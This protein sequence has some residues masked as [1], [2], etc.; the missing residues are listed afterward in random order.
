M[1]QQKNQEAVIAAI[2]HL[3]TQIPEEERKALYRVIA[4]ID[5]LEEL[6]DTGIIAD[7]PPEEMEECLAYARSKKDYVLMFL[8]FYDRFRREADGRPPQEL[9][10]EM[11]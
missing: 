4:N 10:H 6:L 3:L 9:P 2:E 8:V 1:D 11:P 5:Q 7:I